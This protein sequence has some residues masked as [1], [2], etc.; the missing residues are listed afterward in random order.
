MSRMIAIAAMTTTSY[1]PIRQQLVDC[2]IGCHRRPFAPPDLAPPDQSDYRSSEYATTPP[3]SV[4]IG[5]GPAT[6]PPL[7]LRFVADEL[8]IIRFDASLSAMMVRPK[9]ISL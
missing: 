4:L 3:P 1:A 7:K 9:P 6:R 8:A 2:G 5:M